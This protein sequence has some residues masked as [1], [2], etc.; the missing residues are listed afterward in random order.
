[1]TMFR[2]TQQIHL[3]GIG[4]AGMSGIA[5]VLLTIFERLGFR[6]WF[7]S[8]KYREEFVLDDVVVAIDETPAGIFIQ[9]A[10]TTGFAALTHVADAG[11]LA[12]TMSRPKSTISTRQEDDSGSVISPGRTFTSVTVPLSGALMFNKSFCAFAKSRLA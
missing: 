7:R 12:L 2:K 5:E 3:V 11:T 10:G 6:V 1:M 8:E 9:E 4:G